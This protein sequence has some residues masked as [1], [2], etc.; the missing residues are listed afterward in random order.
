[1]LVMDPK[2]IYMTVSYLHAQSIVKDH[3][4]SIELVI[5]F[6]LLFRFS[7]LFKHFNELQNININASKK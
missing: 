1:M 5:F 3:G 7:D 6:S 4:K 2:K